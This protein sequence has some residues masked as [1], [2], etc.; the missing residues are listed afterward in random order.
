MGNDN[1]SVSVSKSIHGGGDQSVQT[2]NTA[3]TTGSMGVSVAGMED[4]ILVVGSDL[5]PENEE[6]AET[7]SREEEQ[8]DARTKKGNVVA[9][10][11]STVE[12]QENAL[13]KIGNVAHYPLDRASLIDRYQVGRRS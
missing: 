10:P 6:T 5:I 1:D 7:F 3:S 8:Q 12:A 11:L 13:K 9:E 2:N 4:M